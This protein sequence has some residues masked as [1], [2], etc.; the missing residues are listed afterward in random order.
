MHVGGGVITPVMSEVTSHLQAEFANMQ[1]MSVIVL[2]VNQEI[3]KPETLSD[4]VSEVTIIKTGTS[5][6][7]WHL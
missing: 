6:H 2:S 1:N 7:A 3:N 5:P 4:G